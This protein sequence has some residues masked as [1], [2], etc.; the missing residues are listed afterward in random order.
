MLCLTDF[1]LRK[2][3]R[4]RPRRPGSRLEI[5]RPWKKGRVVARPDLPKPQKP[6]SWFIINHLV[7][8]YCIQ[9]VEKRCWA[10][11]GAERNRAAL[12]S[13]ENAISFRRIVHVFDYPGIGKEKRITGEFGV[14]RRLVSGRSLF[15]KSLYIGGLIPRMREPEEMDKHESYP[16]K[17]FHPMTCR[18]RDFPHLCQ[19][20][21]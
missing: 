10:A 9:N 11:D 7:E 4:L 14:V 20:T 6:L 13:H 3:I 5:R 17:G 21:S 8:V 1:H 2:R 18:L 12:T 19:L 16:S 15:T